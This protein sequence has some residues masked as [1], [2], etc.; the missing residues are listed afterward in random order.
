M[1]KLTDLDY[2]IN[3]HGVP[4]L[5]LDNEIIEKWINSNLDGVDITSAIEVGCYPGKYLTILGKKGVEVNGIDYIP[6]V[7]VLDQLF[8]KNGYRVGEFINAD[9][10]KFNFEKKF[11]CVMS[12]GFIEHFYNWEEMMLKHLDLVSKKGYVIIEV[13]NF[14]GFFQ[15]LPRMIYDWRNYKRHNIDSMQLEKWIMILDRQGFELVSADYFG[16]YNLWFEENSKNK[17]ILKSRFYLVRLLNKIRIKLFPENRDH[18]SFSS[19]IGV[20]AKRK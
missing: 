9:F 2:W 19:F 15:R 18:K 20:I 8:R 5:I 10:T 13:P 12:F 1:E 17:Y 11:D 6:D 14:K 16:G 3:V 7:V 4:D